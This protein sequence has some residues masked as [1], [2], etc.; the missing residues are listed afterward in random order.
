MKNHFALSREGCY[1]AQHLIE[2]MREG[3]ITA[4]ALKPFSRTIETLCIHPPLPCIHLGSQRFSRRD[5]REDSRRLFQAQLRR[6][7]G[8]NLCEISLFGSR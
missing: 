1:F 2:S 6:C 3:T 5:C 7:I 8:A 4:A